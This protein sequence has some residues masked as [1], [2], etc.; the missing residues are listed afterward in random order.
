MYI[1]DYVDYLNYKKQL[2]LNITFGFKNVFDNLKLSDIEDLDK[3]EFLIVNN[4]E[5]NNKNFSYFYEIISKKDIKLIYDHESYDLSRSFLVDNHIN[6]VMGEAYPKL[7]SL[8]DL[9]D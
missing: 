5:L 9:V 8:K 7:K 2:D 1:L 6:Y 3:A 4:S